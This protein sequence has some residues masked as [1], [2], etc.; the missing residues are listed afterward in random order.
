MTIKG[1]YDDDSVLISGLLKQEEPALIYIYDTYYESVKRYI[2]QNNGT[3]NDVSD[4]FQDAI[5]VTYN[6][7]Q[8]N[9]DLGTSFKEYF[10]GIIRSLWL[11][12]KREGLK[13]KKTTDNVQTSENLNDKVSADDVDNLILGKILARS[14]EKLG[15]KDQTLLLLYYEGLSYQ[16]IAKKM[17]LKDEAQARR[18]KY[19]IKEQLMEI[20]K[21]DSD[22]PKLLESRHR[23]S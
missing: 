21:T 6:F 12:Q 3:I 9:L 11:K 18:K 15:K 19:L 2:L 7:L 16:E 8:E 17:D 23:N 14:I 20:I 1:K 22:Y 4:I 5:I 13:L 10:W